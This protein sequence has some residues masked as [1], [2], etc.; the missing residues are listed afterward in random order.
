MVEQI[1]VPKGGLGVPR[2]N[3]PQIKS[4]FVPDFIDYLETKGIKSTKTKVKVGQIKPTQ[5]EI[6]LDKVKSLVKSANDS[7]LKKPVIV[8]KDGFILDGHHRW[9]ALLQKDKRTA[10]DS[11]KV[12]ATVGELLKL[13]KKYPKT[14]YK[15]I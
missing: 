7:S 2:K 5:G 11:V 14:T 6:N 15:E 10:L 3:M 9:L 8:S 13:A 1:F 4:K 12:D